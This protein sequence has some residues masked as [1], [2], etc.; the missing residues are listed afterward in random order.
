MADDSNG[1]GG[2]DVVDRPEDEGGPMEVEKVEEQAAEAVGGAGAVIEGGG[3][4]DGDGDRAEEVEDGA[5]RRAPVE[6]PCASVTSGAMGSVVEPLNPNMAVEG[7]VIS[8][9]NFRGAS[10]SGNGVGPRGGSPVQNPPHGK[11]PIVAEEEET[12]DVEAEDV[13]F[14]PAA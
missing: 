13:M 8:G 5:D 9:G 2:E 4:G 11:G 10:G 12:R 1:S 3:G 14:Q 7:V 6:I